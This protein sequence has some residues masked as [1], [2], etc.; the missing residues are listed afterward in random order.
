MCLCDKIRVRGSVAKHALVYTVT[1]SAMRL[2][3]CTMLWEFLSRILGQKGSCFV[4]SHLI[5][6]RTMGFRHV[7]SRGVSLSL[8]L[9]SL[10]LF[11]FGF[12]LFCFAGKRLA[13]QL[14]VVVV[15]VVV[16]CAVRESLLC[17]GRSLLWNCHRF[18][19]PS[20]NT[21]LW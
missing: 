11:S 3:V 15:V 19:P 17:A 2:D 7:L 4:S 6:V 1:R 9:S 18:L 16:N 8:S 13:L 5:Q 14:S 10:S 12:R 21:T 20:T